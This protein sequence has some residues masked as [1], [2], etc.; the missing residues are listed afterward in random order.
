MQEQP[1]S[2]SKESAGKPIWIFVL[3]SVA[4]AAL[5]CLS[6]VIVATILFRPDEALST[7]AAQL[8]VDDVTPTELPNEPTIIVESTPVAPEAIDQ[9]PT[10]QVQTLLTPQAGGRSIG[11]P[12]APELGNTGYDVQHYLLQLALDPAVDQ[13]QGAA[14]IQALA[15]IQGLSELAL[16]F[17]GFEVV[18][19][20]V[21]GLA[22]GFE[23][24]GKKLVISL[25]EPLPA[26]DEFTLT[27]TYRGQPLIEPSAY[28]GFVDHLGL[29]FPD[30]LTIY[31][32]AEPDGAR[33]WF[34][35]N[36]HPRDKALFRFEIVVPQGLIAAANGRLVESRAGAM[37][38]GQPG[39]LFIWDHSYPMAP[40]LA[41]VAVGEY[42]RLDDS[43]PAGV[44]I[45]HYTFPEA[46]EDVQAATSDIGQALDWM[47]EL[48]GPYPFETFGY[49]TARVPGGSLETQTLV[50]LSDAMIGK[51]TAVHELAHMWF[52]DW[53][54]LDSW[55]EMWRNEG[56]AT[57]VQL[58]WE[59]RDDPEEL[60]LQMA[61]IESVVEGND[62]S[63]PL[64]NPPPEYL[65][66]LN[67]YYQG[68]MAIH[69]LRQEVG[70]EAFFGGLR[71][72]FERYGGGVASDAEFRA[73]MEESAGRSLEAYFNN[74][75][76]GS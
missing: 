6:L 1:S 7:V 70:D 8:Q 26:G 19:V 9:P 64:H 33:Y 59:T 38:G 11:D 58:M 72:Y 4:I 3:A 65:F 24:A 29:T 20:A 74:W 76:P 55:G 10:P 75:F 2:E 53:V 21:D 30:G 49:V 43:S 27:I 23:R 54:S 17:A 68:A 12:Y 50:I 47:A 52:G 40:Y 15:T 67:V 25:P 13:I 16:D 63:Y 69:A 51:R 18:S 39:Q 57:Y 71:T 46:R 22:A 14:T 61:A 34:P 45:R 56:F 44:P 60:E 37:P 35:A 5:I 41:T 73:V 32:L 42:E 36:D 66:E 48:F 62:K 28:V 31:A